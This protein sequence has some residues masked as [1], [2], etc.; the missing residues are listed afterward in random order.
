MENKL[1]ILI[2]GVILII[3]VFFGYNNIYILQIQ[4]IEER[5][6]QFLL[7]LDKNKVAYK[8][9]AVQK[10]IDRHIKHFPESADTSWLVPKVSAKVR[11]S[12]AEFVAIEPKEIKHYDKFDVIS[13]RLTLKGSYHSLGKFINEIENSD[14]YMRINSVKILKSYK[15]SKPSKV[16]EK[17]VTT[18]E[19][20]DKYGDV[21]GEIDI[22]ICTFYV[23]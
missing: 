7:E 11:K 22:E 10:K 19:S 2:C 4:R 5:K 13:V 9:S 12:K 8:I 23:P 1:T 3:A 14:K 18:S 16:E 17:Q 20:R 15:T 21:L 6:R